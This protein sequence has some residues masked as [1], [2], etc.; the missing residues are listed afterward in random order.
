MKKVD[1]VKELALSDEDVA[2]LRELG[3]GPCWI[4]GVVPPGRRLA[5][6]HDHVTGAVRGLLCSSC[7]RRLGATR[8]S[9]WLRRAAE[10]LDVAA[11]AFGDA[12]DE[13]DK[14]APFVRQVVK[15]GSM[16]LTHR[17]CGETWTCSYLT[18]GIPFAWNMGANPIPPE[19]EPIDA[20]E[21]W[22]DPYGRP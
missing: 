22:G 2:W 6:D 13:C 7:N 4:C 18:R 8:N 16:T 11:R 21:A 12:C 15:C 3:E 9:E 14:P 5:I 10:Y 20:A 1:V 17:C 19:R